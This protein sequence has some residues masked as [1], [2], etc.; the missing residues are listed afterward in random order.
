LTLIFH[1][2]QNRVP[3]LENGH[4]DSFLWGGGGLSLQAT[5]VMVCQHI[6]VIF[7]SLFY[8]AVSTSDYKASNWVDELERMWKEAFVA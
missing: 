4:T 6:C 3:E 7:S 1:T 2:P 8:D 5:A